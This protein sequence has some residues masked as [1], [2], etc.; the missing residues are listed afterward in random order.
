[1]THERCTAVASA[2]EYVSVTT[3]CERANGHDGPHTAQLGP[4]SI[5]AWEAVSFKLNFL[6]ER[7][8]TLAVRMAL[9]EASYAHD[10]P[11]G[12]VPHQF[13]GRLDSPCER[14]Q[15]ADRNPI[16]AMVVRTEK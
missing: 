10:P 9:D 4:G 16:H 1:M 11:L 3:Q 12:E 6:D 5:R 7:H 2:D 8:S 13:V 14:C 15:K